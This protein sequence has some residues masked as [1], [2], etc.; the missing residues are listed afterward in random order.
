MSEMSLTADHLIVIG[1]GRLIADATVD[2]FISRH[3][4]NIVRVRS[5]Q[6][7]DLVA[8][9]AGSDVSV[10]SLGRGLLEIHGLTAEQIG[11]L[12]S[13]KG[14]TLHELTPQQVT[15]EEAFMDITQGELE[16]HTN[17]HAHENE[18]VAA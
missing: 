11:D 17:E 4:E 13:E 18:E 10:T 12:A 14:Y 1:R 7:D 15:L 16:Y 9:V 6:A 5:P 2:E 3:S 8:A